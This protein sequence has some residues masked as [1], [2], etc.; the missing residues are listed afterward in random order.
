LLIVGNPE[1]IHVGAHL[2]NAA[3]SLN[4]RS[5]YA[6]VTLLMRS[7]APWPVAKL[8][9]WVLRAPASRLTPSAAG[10]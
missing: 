8:N 10:S 1:P 2:L 7:A 9:W 5:S 4:Y 6:T 3:R